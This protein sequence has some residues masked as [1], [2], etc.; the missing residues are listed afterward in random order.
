VDGIAAARP[1]TIRAAR[2]APIEPRAGGF[3][4]DIAS[5]ADDA[6]VR[7]L[8]RNASFG[9]DVR[10]SLER[11]PDSMLAASIEGDEHCALIARHVRTGAIAGVASRAVRDAFVNGVPGRI[12][13]LGQLRIDPQFS[14]HRA[15]LAAGFDRVRAEQTAAAPQLH[16]ASVV[17]D[18]VAA[19]RLLSRRA[20]GWPTFEAV[21]NL[22]SL[23]IPARPRNASRHSPDVRCERGSIADLDAIVAC[24]G[25]NGA[26]FQFHPRWSR[27]D[28]T[29][30]RT[31]GL[32]LDDFIVARRDGALV[33]CVACWDQRA[34]KQVR[35]RGYSPRLSRWRPIVNACSRITRAP[36]L[37]RVGE[38]LQFAYLSHLAVDEHEGEGVM[39]DLVAAAVQAA[40]QRGLDYVV[41]GMSAAHPWLSAVRRVFSHRAYE[42]ILYAAFWPDAAALA[43]SLD[44]RPSHPELAIL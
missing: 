21:D 16:L 42:S 43:E 27:A 5:A 32:S 17:A 35:V 18:N 6:E 19:R 44:R 40:C 15:L 24:L 7:G 29:G 30:P 36:H 11:E 28:M 8:L 9:G 37:P 3:A 14:R 23:A 20:R 12:V 1:L 39:V 25:R 41:V 22:L 38:L 26:R 34:F 33:G 4:V 31:R 10:I 2:H 13:Y